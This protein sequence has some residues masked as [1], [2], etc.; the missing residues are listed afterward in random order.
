MC[1]PV[2]PGSQG[3]ERWGEIW[4]VCRQMSSNAGTG[5]TAGRRGCVCACACACVCVCVRVRVRVC[6]RVCVCVCVCVR[7]LIVPY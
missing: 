2:G 5:N 6:V 7:V 4:L 1:T 3:W